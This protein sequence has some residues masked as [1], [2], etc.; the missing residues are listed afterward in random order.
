MIIYKFS[1]N[2]M[3]GALYP[4][5]EICTFHPSRASLDTSSE[6]VHLSKTQ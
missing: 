6:S 5:I 4:H 2:F 1:T 3:R